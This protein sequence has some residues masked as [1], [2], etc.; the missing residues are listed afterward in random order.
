LGVYK[1]IRYCRLLPSKYGKNKMKEYHMISGKRQLFFIVPIY[2]AIIVSCNTLITNS[3]TPTDQI[4]TDTNSLNNLQ[5]TFTE[6]TTPSLSPSTTIT[7]TPTRTIELTWTDLPILEINQAK[8]RINEL[9]IGN[10]DCK[11]PCWWGISPGYT[12]WQES[13]Q[14]FKSLSCVY[15]SNYYDKPSLTTDDVLRNRRY[16]IIGV[17]CFSSYSNIWIL[18]G[19]VEAIQILG[20]TRVYT[21][22]KLLSNYLE[23]NEVLLFTYSN[24]PGS[25]YPFYL[26]LYY[27]D[28]RILSIYELYAQKLG[29]FMRG[30]PQTIEPILFTW[31]NDIKWSKEDIDQISLGIDMN[32]QYTRVKSIN[33]VTEI[34]IEQ[35]YNLYKDPHNELCIDTPNVNWGL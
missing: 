3:A 24:V 28:K 2:I 6:I 25:T 14:L 26:I 30:C 17:D 22:D 27:S 13:D 33:E 16:S 4:I 12:T 20:D 8:T 29:S 18:D 34:T 7:N 31:A 1:F 5:T 15:Y 23:P 35:F 21:L 10:G 19:V 9:I 32:G 11:L